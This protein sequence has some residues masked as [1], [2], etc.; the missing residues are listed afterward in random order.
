M[1][2]NPQA[3]EVRLVTM[4]KNTNREENPEMYQKIKSK[5]D[6]TRSII[7]EVTPKKV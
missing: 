5:I 1:Q 3:E 7:Q 4:L 2:D 6:L